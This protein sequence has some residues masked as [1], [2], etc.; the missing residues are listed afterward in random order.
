[1]NVSDM[2]ESS[3]LDAGLQPGVFWTFML[4]IAGRNPRGA[5]WTARDGPILSAN[6][7]FAELV[8]NPCER[9][10]GIP[11]SRYVRP[12]DRDRFAS[13]LREVAGDRSL[14]DLEHSSVSGDVKQA[15]LS[16]SPCASRVTT[17]FC[18]GITEPFE[19]TWSALE[20]NSAGLTR[21]IGG[22]GSTLSY[23]IPT[24]PLREVT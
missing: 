15:R 5:V 22:K 18:I 8:G 2:Q 10:V 20:V 1:M 14:G 3:E 6:A 17:G 7:R 16:V 23:I 4:H 11:F 9:L 21:S 12:G 13:L 24:T 19:L